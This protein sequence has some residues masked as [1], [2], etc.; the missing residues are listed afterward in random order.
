MNGDLMTMIKSLLAVLLLAFAATAT[1]ALDARDL[2]PCK[3][4]AAR[5]CDHSDTSA[6]IT[7]L[8]RCGA[9]LASLS[10]RVGEPCREVLRRYGQL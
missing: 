10:H 8:M 6:S 3:P 9:T 1:A 5:Y 4:A 2:A 7:N